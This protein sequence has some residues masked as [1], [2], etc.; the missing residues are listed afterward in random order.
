MKR[1]AEIASYALFAVLSP[2]LLYF[3]WKGAV[4]MTL[5]EALGFITGVVCVWLCVKEHI[6]NWPIGLAN[7]V[8]YIIVFYKARLFADTGLQVMYL[9]LGMLG[10]YWW[11]HGGLQKDRLEVSPMSPRTGVVLAALVAASTWGMTIYLARI[12]DSAPFLDALTSMMSIAAQYMVTKKYLENWHIWIVVDVIY[13]YLYLSRHL[14]L[15]SALYLLYVIMAVLGLLAWRESMKSTLQKVPEWITLPQ[16]VSS[17]V[18]AD[19][20]PGA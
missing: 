20:S 5:T 13:V 15:T 16:P 17:P 6:W 19:T 11:L 4:S 18:I 10:W 3:A 9:V 12:H 2:V 14:Y 8:F 7:S 1:K